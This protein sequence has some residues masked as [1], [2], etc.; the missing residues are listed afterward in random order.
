MDY[1]DQ[2]AG[3]WHEIVDH[4]AIVPP[5]PSHA[6]VESDHLTRDFEKLTRDFKKFA[7]FAH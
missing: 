1:K 2:G 7:I 4:P 6:R 5:V 3:S